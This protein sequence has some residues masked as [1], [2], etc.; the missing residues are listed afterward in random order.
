VPPP[1][2]QPAAPVAPPPQEVQPTTPANHPLTGDEPG[3]L[4][5]SNMPQG[6]VP[7]RVGVLL[8][9]S[10]GSA[11]TRALAKSLMNAAQLA[12]FDARNP[13]ILLISADEGSTS[14]DA[15]A[16]ARGLLA[17]G[18]EV[19]VGPLFAA[20]VTAVAPIARDRAVPVIAFS[21][22]RN[23]AGDD[24]YL[25][26]FQ[27]ENDVKRVISYAAAHGHTNFAA[28]IPRTA[29]GERIASALKAEIEADKLQLSD[30]ER[31]DPGAADLSGPAHA[32]AASNADAIL[33]AQ[34]GAPLRSM[35]AMLGT[36]RARFKLLGTGLWDDRSL[37][38]ESML[39]GGWFAAPPPNA[40][41]TFAAKYRA[42][43]GST[44]PQ[45]AALAYD[46]ISLVALLA[47]GTPY[48]RFTPEALTD[49]NGFSGV[50]GVFRFNPDGTSERG[51]AI[52]GVEPEGFRVVD[53]APRTFQPQGS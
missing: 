28:L 14:Q 8:P 2:P 39:E 25:L 13:D 34:G 21:T 40:D 43:F 37:T 6:R 38:R 48:H 49:P 12:I 44:P 17:Q 5:L 7:V 11:S 33:I 27:P 10:N 35:A 20:S 16:A 1:P 4:R 26:S 18:A 31:F 22:D 41:E 50:S 24:V 42:V 30:I 53:P 36:D 19:I 52:L 47:P 15:A 3:F 9:F 32:V 46:A 51:L 23:V 45:L 29:Y